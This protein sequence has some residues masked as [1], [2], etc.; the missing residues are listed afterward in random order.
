M[1]VSVSFDCALQPGDFMAWTLWLNVL[2]AIKKINHLIAHVVFGSLR[3]QQINQVKLN[4]SLSTLKFYFDEKNE[5]DSLY[6]S[7]FSMC[8]CA[9]NVEVLLRMLKYWNIVQFN[10]YHIASVFHFVKIDASNGQLEMTRLYKAF[11]HVWC[12]VR[13]VARVFAFKL[14]YEIPIYAKVR[15]FSTVKHSVSRWH[16]LK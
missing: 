10:L 3:R 12:A 1:P 4:F 15:I 16:K 8:I 6:F 14:R 7:V 11:H 2:A 13:L 9:T 5:R